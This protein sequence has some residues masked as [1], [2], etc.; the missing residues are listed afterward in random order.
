MAD[1]KRHSHCASRT[2]ARKTRVKLARSHHALGMVSTSLPHAKTSPPH[3]K[4]SWQRPVSN[5]N[6][7]PEE[8]EEDP[9]RRR[10]GLSS[11]FLL[12]REDTC[13]KMQ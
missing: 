9:G 1:G 10:V 7:T 4:N 3:A 11:P 5:L 12:P 2:R 6:T 8:E 13:L